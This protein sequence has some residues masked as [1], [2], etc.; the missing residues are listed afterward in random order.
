MNITKINNEIQKTLKVL[1]RSK[2]FIGSSVMKSPMITYR[3]L[4]ASELQN[5]D[6][7][8]MLQE[9]GDSLPFVSPFPEG[10]FFMEASVS[11]EDC[12]GFWRTV[13]RD[14]KSVIQLGLRPILLR[15]VCWLMDTWREDGK[16]QVKSMVYGDRRARLTREQCHAVSVEATRQFAVACN[17]FL[18]PHMHP[19]RVRE[20]KKGK[21][22]EWYRKREYY[23]VVPRAHPANNKSVHDGAQVVLTPD[24]V[25]RCAHQV[26]AHTRLLRHPRWGESVGKRITVKAAWR[27]AREWSEGNQIY[28]LAKT[29]GRQ[30]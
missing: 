22:V 15:G 11:T 1:S 19:V 12:V 8:N 13:K 23:K 21:S 7:R 25:K 28:T 20:N 2:I 14:G 16:Y 4:P 30:Q 24:A 9:T 6:I 3:F 26:R 10:R 29:Q 27:G 5:D 18:S 17:L